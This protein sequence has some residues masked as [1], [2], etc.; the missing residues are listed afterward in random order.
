MTAES[1]SLSARGGK[2]RK[3]CDWDRVDAML[4]KACVSSFH[5]V[6]LDGVV[7]ESA[8]RVASYA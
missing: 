5:V 2:G 6:V 8:F 1:G 3:W 7:E 4:Q